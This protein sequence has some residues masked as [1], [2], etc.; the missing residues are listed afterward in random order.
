M[1]FHYYF[2]CILL[3]IRPISASAK[4]S[5]NVESACAAGVSFATRAIWEPEL[6]K[7][8]L[9]AIIALLAILP[10][11]L[12][13]T[14]DAGIML[15]IIG[16][17]STDLSQVAIHAS[18][19]DQSERLVS[20]LGVEN[21]SIG[22]DL[23]GLA[24]VQDVENITD[25]DL[26]FATV[27]VMDTSSSMADRPLTQA[28]AA[29]RGYIEALEPDDPVAVVTFNTEVRQ[30]IDYTTDR[31]RLYATIDNLAYGGQT[32]LYDA[33]LRGIE[34]AV[35]AP[36]ERKAVVILSDGGKY[37]DV[38]ESSRDESIRR[39]HNSRRAGVFNWPGLVDRP[40][41]PRSDRFRIQRH[42]LQFA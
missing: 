1:G 19:L 35:E 12:A 33:T 42:L 34:L 40:A 27:L 39:G 14:Q 6:N 26:N 3:I 23:H 32:A 15:D 28:Q 18:I 9:R 8:Q 37:G 11:S 21:F 13:S 20:G 7:R 5:G 38:S 30:V 10:F 17:T 22:G 25:D 29:A 36:L 31:E 16:I 24:E 41:F 2:R 4:N